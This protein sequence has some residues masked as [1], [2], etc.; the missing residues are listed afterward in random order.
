LPRYYGIFVDVQDRRC[1]VF[2]GDAH[3]AERKVRYFLECGG[4]VTLF[5]PEED[6]STGLKELAA[7]GEID[8]VQ[9]T[10][11]P[12]DLEGA[13]MV[14]VA[15]TSNSEIN[16]AISEEAKER[17]VLLNVMDVTPLCTFIAP[18]LVH[19]NDVTVAATTAG[20]SPA[21]ARR[22]RVEMTSERC[23]CLRWADAG[24][25]LGDVRR[26][27]RS[28]GLVICPEKWQN[29]MTESWLDEVRSGDADQARRQLV[30]GL[31]SVACKSCQPYGHCMRL[32]TPAPSH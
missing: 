10:Y 6:T 14:V 30:E 25:M 27:I 22:L 3:E 21:L 2:G 7:A 17:N 1:L 29:F 12:G 28:R 18:A 20:T 32:E 26:E 9:R 4:S 8:W 16:Q 15:D 5:S 24:P 19:R 13:W 31:E 11:Q 23:S